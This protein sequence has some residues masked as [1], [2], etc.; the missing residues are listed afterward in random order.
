MPISEQEKAMGP[1]DFHDNIRHANS[2]DTNTRLPGEFDAPVSAELLDRAA[3]SSRLKARLFA[4]R[5]D[6]DVEAGIIPLSGSSLAVHIARL[7][8]VE[9]REAL[10]RTLRQ[11]LA[12]LHRDRRGFSPRIPVHPGR[13]ASCRGVIDDITLL[14]H[15]PRPVRARGMAR[16][17]LLL[18]D[19]TGPLYSNGRGSLAAELRGVLAA[20]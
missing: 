1:N 2:R 12:E 14:L 5:L 4:G 3:L 13:L 20:L 19:G 8:S 7:T 18:A 10:A 11:A 17:R 15:S 9:E 16:L 6:R